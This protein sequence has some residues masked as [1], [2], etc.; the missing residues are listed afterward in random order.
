MKKLQQSSK[1]RKSN[2]KTI[3]IKLLSDDFWLYSNPIILMINFKGGKRAEA[4]QWT[5]EI[6]KM[7]RGIVESV[8]GLE[9]IM[10]HTA[11]D[12]KLYLENQEITISKEK[13]YWLMIYLIDNAILRIYACLDKI[14]QMCRCYFEHKDNDGALEVIRKCGCKEVMGEDNCNFGSLVTYLN[15]DNNKENR[16]QKV[17]G[18]LNKLNT[19]KAVSNLRTYRNTFT[20]RKHT[21]DQTVGLDPRVH[22]EYKSDGIVETQFNFGEQLPSLNWFRVEIVNANNAIVEFLNEIQ[23]VIF[24]RD[25][26][27]TISK[28]SR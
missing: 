26:S 20:H 23:G 16:N 6:Q 8:I 2:Q 22:S 24:P 9:N 27:L 1:D 18:A 14:A 3:N 28:K 13:K 17:V 25:F 10:N 19:D 4:G 7:L 5:L 12:K 21:M 11:T 15:S